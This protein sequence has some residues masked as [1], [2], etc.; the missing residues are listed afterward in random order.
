MTSGNGTD[1]L[2]GMNTTLQIL[3][4]GFAT[5]ISIGAAIAYHIGRH[6]GFRDGYD[7]ALDTRAA[8]AK[9][10]QLRSL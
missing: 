3:L 9:K 10:Y 1:S 8:V 4:I 5:G 2:H 6:R 7:A